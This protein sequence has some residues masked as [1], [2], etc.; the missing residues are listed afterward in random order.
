MGHS[1]VTQQQRHPSAFCDRLN[2]KRLDWLSGS[3]EGGEFR[4]PLIQGVGSTVR[5]RP[6]ACT[7]IKMMVI[8][9]LIS[10]GAY[11]SPTFLERWAPSITD[12]QQSAV[13]CST[14]GAHRH[15]DLYGS[16]LQ[17]HYL[18]LTGAVYCRQPAPEAS[19][20]RFHNVEHLI[21]IQPRQLLSFPCL[22]RSLTGTLSLQQ[23]SLASHLLKASK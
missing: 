20:S 19:R 10:M 7:D 15:L 22:S 2:A 4:F 18:R 23:R 9:I 8:G 21:Y 1:R 12:S 14:G 17:R 13:T 5:L 16:T 11:C 3:L 6:T